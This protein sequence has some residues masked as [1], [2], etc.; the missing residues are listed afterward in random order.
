MS[1][2]TGRSSIGIKK[3]RIGISLEIEF[4]TV[5]IQIRFFAISRSFRLMSHRQNCDGRLI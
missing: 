4:R 2:S 1:T 3:N 5:L